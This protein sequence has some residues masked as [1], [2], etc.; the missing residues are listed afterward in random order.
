M[1][2]SWS[3]QAPA[4]LVGLALIGALFAGPGAYADHEPANKF[5]AAG[6][7][8]D[9]VDDSEPILTERMK[10]SSS[11]DLVLSA[12]AECSILTELVTDSD[13][14]SST[15][16]GSVR[17]WITLDG[18]RVPVSTDDTAEDNDDVVEDD[19]DES[20]IGEVTFCNRAYSR[21]VTDDESPADGIDREEDFI[22]TRTANAFN[23]VATDVGFIYDDPSNGNNIIEVQLWADYDV[24]EAG[25]AAADAFVGTRT[26]I[27]EPT[28]LSVHEAVEP[29]CEP[30]DDDPCPNP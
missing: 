2:K 13:T 5:A 12:S 3:R 10:V 14:P 1:L 25:N 30:A 29:G 11:F 19:G 4:M 8:I 15:A 28:N 23:W 18:K 21:T 16:F 24:S 6:S 27:A 17:M 9:E 26:L 20:D 7:D 22:D